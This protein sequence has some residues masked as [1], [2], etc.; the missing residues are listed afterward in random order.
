MNEEQELKFK[1]VMALVDGGAF[2]D[3]AI[4]MVHKVFCF[5]ANLDHPVAEAPEFE[6]EPRAGEVTY[7][8]RLNRRDAMILHKIIGVSCGGAVESVWEQLEGMLGDGVEDST[9]YPELRF[10]LDPMYSNL[11]DWRTIT[12]YSFN[13]KAVD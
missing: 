12:S 10:I 8:L 11:D 6:P 7:V 4:E 5:A 2:V 1:A 3:D 13:W 9:D